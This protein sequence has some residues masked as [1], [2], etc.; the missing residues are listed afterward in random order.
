LQSLVELA[1]YV[2]VAEEGC[3]ADDLASRPDSPIV[4]PPTGMD[5]FGAMKQVVAE[6]LSLGVGR[7][8]EQ[9]VILR[10]RLC[11]K[12]RSRLRQIATV[13]IRFRWKCHND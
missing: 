7:S 4:I 12:Y 13:S 5:Q 11:R 3:Y 2:V 1:K 9:W 10:S 8:A 6:P